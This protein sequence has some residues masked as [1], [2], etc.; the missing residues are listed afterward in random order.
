MTAANQI[1]ATSISLLRSRTSK[2]ALQGTLIGVA[3]AILATVMVGYYHTGSISLDGMIQAQMDNAALWVLDLTPFTFAFWGQYVNAMMA[4]E[5]SVLVF[6]QTNELRTQA[7]ALEFE[8][9]QTVDLTAANVLLKREVEERKIA[10]EKISRQSMV[11][12]AINRIL[13]ERIRTETEEELGKFCLSVAEELTGSTFGFLG[14]LN[15]KG[16]FETIA[17]SNPGWEKCK[18]PEGQAICVTEDMPV[19]GVA[20]VIIKEGKSRI[21]NGEEAVRNHPDYD[22]VPEGHPKITSFL[23]VPFRDKGKVI[24]MIGLGNKEGGY[25]IADQENVEALSI[26]MFEVLISKRAEARVEHLACYDPLTGLSNRQLFYDR[27]KQ[28][29]AFARRRANVLAVLFLDLDDFKNIND[30]LGH[31]VG[32]LFL[33]EMAKRLKEC[34]READTVARLGGD[35]FILI[36]EEINDEQGAISVARRIIASLAEPVCFQEH[37]LFSSVSIGITLFPADGDDVE[38]LVKNADMAMYRAKQEG[39]NNYQLFTEAMNLKAIGR[40]TMENN[41]RRAVEQRE[42]LIYYQPKV[43]LATGTMIGTEALVRWPLPDGTF[44]SPADFIPVTEATGLII[45]IGEHVLRTACQQAR[46]WHE[47]GYPLS[48]AVNLSP[49]QF[50]QKNLVETVASILEETGLAAEALELE[51]TE[52]LVMENRDMAVDILQELKQ[53]GIRIS[54]DDFGT[55]YSSLSYLKQLPIDTLKVDIAFIRDIPQS[56]DDVAITLAIIAMAK[57]LNLKVVAEGV[58]TAEQLAF[59][60]EHGCDQMQGY[61]FSPPVPSDQLCR[62]LEEGRPLK[63]N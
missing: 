50:R 39:K 44:V 58:E 19:C 21:V 57:S 43:C 54:M 25:S 62:H 34:C 59:L 17:I 51:I 30:S 5:A 8:A 53:M 15:E 3:A 42:F 45:P 35:E 13:R 22:E 40:L 32:D 49:R 23:G 31:Q 26:S 11:L 12:E 7:A 60:K 29:L 56:Q 52:T 1:L 6:D 2:Y 9:K 38:T 63:L 41:L 48:V 47:A 27:L 20:R 18:V 61:L 55:G 14:E 10:E 16:L 33:Q 36:L 24:G 46:S 28:A 4:Y 37:E